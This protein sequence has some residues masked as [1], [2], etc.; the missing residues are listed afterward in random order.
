MKI[1]Y[2]SQYFPPEIGAPA[3]RVYELARHWVDAGH[4]VTVLTGFPN[5][6]SGVLPPG[7]RR[8]WLRLVWCER[9]AG[10]QVVRAWLLPFANRRACRRILNF[11]SFWLSSSFVGSFLPQPDVVIATSPQLLVGLA[12]WWLGKVK[13]APFLFEVRDLW[14]ESLVAVGAFRKQSLVYR[15]TE[16]V[17]RFLY[18]RSDHIVVV[19]P[20]YRDYLVA[21]W[22]IA[23]ERIS[24]VENGVQTATF[25]PGD[26]SAIRKELR[27]EE[28]FVVSYIG[29]IGMAHGLATLMETAQQASASLSN[30]VFLLVGD[31]AEKKNL[32]RQ[33]GERGL[34]NVVFVGQKPRELIP[35]YIRASDAC[36]VL[37][38]KQD[39][40]KTVIPTKLLE[41]MACGR[42]VIL[43]VEGQAREIV[44]TAGAGLCIEPE[45]AA[46]L[47]AAIHRLHA[48]SELRKMLG[49]NGRQCA[50]D[51]FSREQM[52]AKYM[53]ILDFARRRNRRANADVN[54][55]QDG[56]SESLQTF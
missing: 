18:R 21:K 55:R 27:L 26:K 46:E 47:A 28:K 52:A 42:P 53:D 35:D 9:I 8:R 3:A 51:R 19:A 50:A 22:G 54:L 5:H 30:V 34:T 17:A 32:Q 41:F 45:N 23:K 39:I 16:R 13:R 15:L 49:L 56:T 40:F 2:V 33:A 25:S 43:G 44:D 11:V 1:L 31:G 10:I 36:L 37:L 14:P 12:G 38:R 4:Q 48:D 20:A 24:V 29:T 7:Y 6:P